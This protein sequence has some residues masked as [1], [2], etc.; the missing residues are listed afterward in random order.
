MLAVGLLGP[1]VFCLLIVL[2]LSGLLVLAAV[3]L[4]VAAGVEALLLLGRGGEQSLE[5]LLEFSPFSQTPFPQTAFLFPA[6]DAGSTTATSKIKN[7]KPEKLRLFVRSPVIN[8]IYPPLIIWGS[9]WPPK[10]KSL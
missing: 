6:A 7:T 8:A 2:G 4:L 10:C 9:Q 5:Q 3:F 1:P